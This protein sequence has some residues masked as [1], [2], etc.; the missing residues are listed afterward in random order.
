MSDISGVSKPNV[1]KSFKAA[2][3]NLVSRTIQ[4]QGNQATQ[5]V[6]KEP[7]KQDNRSKLDKTMPYVAAGASAIAI[8]A[9][10]VAIAGNRK[11]SKAVLK[12]LEQIERQMATD[13]GAPVDKETLKNTTSF[14]VGILGAATGGAVVNHFDKNKDTLKKIGMTDDEINN[15]KIKIENAANERDGRVGRAENAAS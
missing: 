13:K 1:F 7:Q 5:V 4:Q 11:N 2:P 9:S 10:A 12:K 8:G 6:T 3:Q 14:I 15:S